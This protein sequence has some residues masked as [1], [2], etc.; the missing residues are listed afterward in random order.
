MLGGAACLGAILAALVAFSVRQQSQTWDEAYHI[1]AGYRY[2]QASDFGINSEHPPFVKLLAALPLL[3]LRPLIP[4]VPQGTTKA[5]GFITA[6]KFLYSNDADTLL[7]RCRLAAGFFTLLLALLIW[8]AARRMFGPRPAFLA[9]MLAV[10]EPNFL[11]HGALVTTDMGLAC[12]LFAAVYAFYRYLE[13][14]SLLRLVESG[15]VAGLALAAKH[16][17]I[18]VFPILGSLALLDLVMPGKRHPDWEG[19]PAEEGESRSRHALRLGVALFTVTIIAAVVLWGFYAFRFRARPG[20]QAMTTPLAQYIRGGTTPGL[21]SPL[22]SRVILS[23]ERMQLLP[24]SYLYGMADVLIVSAG[25]RPSYLF[26]RLYPQGRWFYFPAVF[27]IKSTLGFLLLLA[28]ALAANNLRRRELRRDFVFL[29]LPAA[30]YFATSLTSGLNVGVR[31]ILPVYPFLLVL[32]AAGAWA[33][34]E[35]RRAWAVAVVAL[36]ALHVVS[37]LRAYP[38][39][40][41]YSNEVWGGTAN[42]FRVLTDSNVEWGQSLKTIKQYL[43]RERITECW[44]A[45]FGSADPAYYHIPCKLLP[46]VFAPWWGKPVDVVPPAYQGTLLIGATELASNY[47]GPGELNPYDQFRS[48][49]PSENLDG[50]TLVF[51]GRFDLTA[52]SELSRLNKAWELLAD[53]HLEQAIAESRT[54]VNLAPRMVYAHYALGYLL[55]QAKQTSEARREYEAAL[56]LAR[57][58]YPEFQWYWVPF[59]EQQLH[60]L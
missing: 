15:F 4:A 30:I 56:A 37:S 6:R 9:L 47:L 39:Y 35:R 8:E 40:L 19:L 21:K 43:D 32:A 24:E 45:Y 2:W 51:K 5:E 23:F 22:L 34:V 14:P 11:A 54:V 27:V 13:A 31:H 12:C 25:P 57:S 52:A 17:G 1:L 41:A 44:L 38:Y 60:S 16:S 46:D 3:Y 20:S 36:V 53:H 10:F 7:L 42:T 50:A 58:V 29:V 26:G 33:L 18:L 55:A 49:A 28:L 59:L 48:I